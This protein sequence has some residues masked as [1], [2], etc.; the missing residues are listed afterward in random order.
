MVIR[1]TFDKKLHAAI[2]IDRGAIFVIDSPDGISSGE[3]VDKQV[4][5][6]SGDVELGDWHVGVTLPIGLIHVVP[7]GFTLHDVDD[8]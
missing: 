8:G 1:R 6:A 4:L 5:I 2:L 7:W 3:E